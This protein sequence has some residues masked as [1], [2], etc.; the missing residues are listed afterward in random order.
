MI[1]GLFIRELILCVSFWF[2]FGLGT[3]AGIIGYEIYLIIKREK[4]I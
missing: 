4:R 3:L 2:G 1:K